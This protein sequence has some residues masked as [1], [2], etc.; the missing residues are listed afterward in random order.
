M[1]ASKLDVR[2]YKYG[3]KGDVWTDR[4][5]IAEGGSS[6]TLCARPM[7]ARNW[8]RLLEHEDVRCPECIKQY[9]IKIKSDK[10]GKK[11]G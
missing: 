5:H 4:V 9:N 1:K 10:N 3:N 6:V 7:L 2:F 8:A 11:R